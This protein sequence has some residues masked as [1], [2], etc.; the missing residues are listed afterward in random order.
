MGLRST[1]RYNWTVLSLTGVD[2]D[3]VPQRLAQPADEFHTHLVISRSRCSCVRLVQSLDSIA[4]WSGIGGW[5]EVFRP[6]GFS[7]DGALSFLYHQTAA[8]MSQVQPPCGTHV[9][10]YHR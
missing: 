1:F 9:V 4:E 8:T 6:T 7:T 3:F 2:E 10:P 5:S